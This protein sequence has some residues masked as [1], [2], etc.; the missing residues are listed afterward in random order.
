VLK[1][2]FRGISPAKLVRKFLNVRSPWA[3]KFTEITALVPFFNSHACL[4]QSSGFENWLG[5]EA[6]SQVRFP[7]GWPGSSQRLPPNSCAAGE[8][9]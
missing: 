8:E 5:S 4:Q 9:Q 2:S 7:H 1:N 3:L 6:R